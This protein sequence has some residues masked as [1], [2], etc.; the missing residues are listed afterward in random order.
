M[1][2]H[3]RTKS[4]MTT[5]QSPRIPSPLR[6]LLWAFW[7]SVA[8]SSAAAQAQTQSTP[9]ALWEALT[10]L[11]NEMSEGQLHISSIEATPLAGIYEVVLSSGEILYGD[12]SG[13][14]LFIG[15]S[16]YEVVPDGLYSLSEERRRRWVADKLATVPQSEMIIFSPQTEPRRVINVFTDVDCGYC[17][18]LHEDMDYLLS[19]G[20]EVR[21]L[22]FPRGGT[23][24][25]SFDKM[26]SV[27]CSADRHRTITQAKRGQNLPARYCDSPVLD[28]Y[29]LGNALRVQGTPAI[30]TPEGH[31]IAGYAGK[32]YLPAM[33]GLETE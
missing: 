15:D 30:F 8:L 13:G 9:D 11:L 12:G 25:G 6:R 1:K 28:H 27:W 31:L 32:E 4:R 16:L 20:I 10:P 7:L 26:V 19:L 2:S 3:Q 21:Y 29:A 5:R 24:A 23:E 17:R 33:L 14:Y 18:R 22:A